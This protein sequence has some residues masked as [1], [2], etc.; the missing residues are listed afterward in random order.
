MILKDSKELLNAT[1]TATATGASNTMTDNLE[2]FFAVIK[3]ASVTGTS[4]TFDV[5]VDHSH[6]GTDWFTLATFTQITGATTEIKTISTHVME[7]VRYDMTV[8]GTTPSAALEVN[9]VYNNTRLNS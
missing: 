3:V 8:G 5:T 1:V 4:P 6:N 7:Y 2:G 9:L